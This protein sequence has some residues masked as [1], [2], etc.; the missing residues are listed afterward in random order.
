[1]PEEFYFIYGRTPDLARAEA[2]AVYPQISFSEVHSVVDRVS[3]LPVDASIVMNRLG[4]LIRIVQL[5]KTFSEIDPTILADE[6]HTYVKDHP[7]I[8]FTISVVGETGVPNSFFLDVKRRL[9]QFHSHVRFV[10]PTQGSMASA[11]QLNQKDLVEFVLIESQQGILFCSTRSFQFAEEWSKRDFDR[12]SANAKR[13]M[14]PPK[15]ARMAINIA[16][17]SESKH[18]VIADPFCGSGTVL[19]EGYMLGCVCFGSDVSA[20][21]VQDSIQNSHW[22]KER[23]GIDTPDPV[24]FQQDAVHLSK[25]LEQQTLDAIVTEPFLGNPS[26]GEGKITDKEHIKDIIKGLEKLYTGC[27]KDWH[28]LLKSDGKVVIALPLIVVEE[29]KQTVKK[30]IDTCE[31]LGYSIE[32][33]PLEYSRPKAIVRRQF[34]ILRKI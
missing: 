6:I 14:L 4:G 9:Q 24:I 32:A 22:L 20:K 34:Y 23:E 21:A 13:G 28:P 19:S 15:V 16:V 18:K 11:F 5:Q 30:L 29:Y 1:M 2:R 17:G 25:K 7:S 3:L 33:G 12:P 26:L 31:S 27:L 8:M 10:P